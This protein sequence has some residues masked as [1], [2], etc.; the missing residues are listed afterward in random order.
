MTD[1]TD[2]EKTP[3][4]WPKLFEDIEEHK[5]DIEH[6][7]FKTNMNSIDEILF[8]IEFRHPH[9]SDKLKLL[10][11]HPEFEIEIRNLVVAERENRAGFDKLILNCLLK[12]HELHRDKYQHT[13]L[14]SVDIW[15]MNRLK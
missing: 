8:E 1:L 14:S 12:L 5:Q 3:L 4:V 2:I 7:E 11:G 6:I 9:I 10:L 13:T 15:E